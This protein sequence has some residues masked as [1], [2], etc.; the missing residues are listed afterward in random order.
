[1]ANTLMKN[2]SD[3][4]VKMFIANILNDIDCGKFDE[5]SDEESMIVSSSMAHTNKKSSSVDDEDDEW[6]DDSR[7]DY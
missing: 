2:N 1:M 5:S 3:E 4:T 6:E 7:G